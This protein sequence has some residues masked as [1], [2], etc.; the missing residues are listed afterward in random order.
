MRPDIYICSKPL[1]YFNIRNIESDFSDARKILIIVDSFLDANLFVQQVRE[2]DSTWNKI[3][4]FA[5][6]YQVDLYLLFHP[7]N[8]LFVEVDASFVYGILWK[9][10]RFRNMYIYEEGFGSYRRD[11]F[12]SS[13]GLKKWINKCTG[14]GSHIGFSDFL[15]GQYLY[16]PELYKSQFP[17][18]TKKLKT[19]GKLFVERLRE[20]LPLFLKFSEGYDEF[21]SIR[22]KR[23]GLY[24][25]NHQ[26]NDRIITQ[27]ISEGVSL[28]LLYVKPHPHIKDCTSIQQYNLTVIR[29]N[30]M[31]EFLLI[32]LLDNGNEVTVFHEN[33]TSVI[34]FQNQIVNRNLGEEFKEYDIVASYIKSMMP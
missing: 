32:I 8:S 17:A 2:F 16:L 28:D 11:R 9:L 18:Y 27:F 4:F 6:L 12:Y 7:A 14:V 3:L 33:S 19:F 29:S 22:N 25:S 34:W 13:K 21:K 26:I 5:N 10:S 24:L 31:V 20:E 1:Q 30:I 23:V 15:T